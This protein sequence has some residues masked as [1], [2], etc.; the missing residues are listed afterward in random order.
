MLLCLEGED[1]VFE[2]CSPGC[3]QVLTYSVI[4]M[5][6]YFC[7]N[8]GSLIGQIT[9]AFSEYY[10]GYWLSFTLPTIMFLTCPFVMIWCRN[11]YV[12]NPP[13]GS[14]LGK[15]LRVV[16]LAMKG[17]W[18]WNPVRTI[19]NIQAPGFWESAKPSRQEV[20]PAW[21]TFDDAWV[22]EVR[23]GLKA[24]AVFCWFPIY[25]LSYNQLNNNLIS[26]AGTMRL[27][28]VPND[29]VTNLDPLALLIFIPI[30]DKFIYPAIARTGFQFTPIKKITTGF[31]LGTLSMVVAAIIQHYIYVYSPCGDHADGCELG[32]PEQMS[33]WIQTP[34]YVL[35][36]LSEIAAS[37]TG[38]EYAFT[39]APKN[40]RGLVTGVFFFAQAFSSALAQA[41]VGLSADPL[42]VW[43]YTTVAI[44]SAIA[45]LGFWFS[46]SKLDKEEEALNNLPDSVF[47]GS[48]NAGVDVEAT[49][50]TK[51]AQ[52]KLRSAQ[53]LD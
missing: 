51:A 24:C 15:S 28:G 13:T 9:M 32:K 34:A 27:D 1:G 10:V 26:Q 44:I 17:R 25:W 33:V 11:K 53:G 43:L 46:F 47:Q 52:E 23:R 8:V 40:M 41:F 42:L 45:G 36:A 20:K 38:L 4:Y 39:K 18:S 14:V 12:R 50:A 21:M 48:R 30:C 7:I 2:I 22:D 5:R 16:G 49:L 29:I 31:A 35:I 6:Y 3:L 37:I 19:R